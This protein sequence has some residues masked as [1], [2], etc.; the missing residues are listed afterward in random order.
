LEARSVPPLLEVIDLHKSFGPVSALRGA[1]LS[2]EAGEVL[3]LVGDNGAGK[4]TLIKHIAGVHRPDSGEIRLN[5]VLLNL[6][7]PADARALGI[8]TVYQDLALADDLSVGANVFLGREP[9]KRWLGLPVIDGHRIRAETEA[10]LAR[11]ESRIPP[12]REPC[13]A[14]QAVSAKPWPSH[15]HSTGSQRSLSSTSLPHRSR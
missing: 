11:I 5:G 15:A 13:R 7:S 6:H 12:R 1:S 2:L 8:E 10:L 14:C 4:T 9:I 3:A